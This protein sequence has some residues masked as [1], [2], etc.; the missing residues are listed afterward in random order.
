MMKFK[1]LYDPYSQS[2]YTID[3]AAMIFSLSS[4]DLNINLRLKTHHCAILLALFN[5]HPKLVSYTSIKSILKKNKLTCPDE[6]RLHRK[7]SELRVLLI[8]EHP[9]LKEFISNTR[10]VGYNL[11]IHLKEP[12][13]KD[14]TRRDVLSDKILE[15]LL[16]QLDKLVE[17]SCELSEKSSIVKVDD[18]FVLKRSDVKIEL[19]KI[20]KKFVSLNDSML[21]RL[22]LHNEDFLMIRIQFIMA[23]LKTY[24]GLARISE[25]SITKQQWDDWHQH[26]IRLVLEELMQ[27]LKKA[28][29]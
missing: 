19:G 12:V 4:E 26:E 27:L 23:K 2:I 29:T 9:H 8:K 18:A 21:K 16:A 7:I 11:P 15:K 10:S 13:D 20:I 28:T 5:E 24:I 22:K 1:Q 3:G 25:F 14:A 17:T 6:T